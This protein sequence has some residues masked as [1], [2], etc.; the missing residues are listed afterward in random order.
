[1][2]ENLEDYADNYD[3][4]ERPKFFTSPSG[5]IV[6]IEKENL[7]YSFKLN[8]DIKCYLQFFMKCRRIIKTAGMGDTIS[9]TGFIYHPPKS[10]RY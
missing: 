2:T 4:P 7:T 9:S 8:P 5:E 3:I 6:K 10:K 1:M